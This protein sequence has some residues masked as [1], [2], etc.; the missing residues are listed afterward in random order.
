M[1]RGGE[2]A[3]VADLGDD[4]DRGELTDTA[5]RLQGSNQAGVTAVASAFVEAGFDAS[6]ALHTTTDDVTGIIEDDA[7]GGTFEVQG[8]EPAVVAGRRH[9]RP[10]RAVQAAGHQEVVE[11][12]TVAEQVGVG[13]GASPHQAAERFVALV[14]HP[15]RIEVAAAQQAGEHERVTAIVFTR[16]L[17]RRG[18]WAGATTR[19]SMPI[20]LS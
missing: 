1:R 19:H 17:A 6:L 15:D 18:I 7:L 16:S 12:V 8:L 4:G 9:A 3:E 5:E 14:G 13:V 20:A 2:A 10:D 11:P